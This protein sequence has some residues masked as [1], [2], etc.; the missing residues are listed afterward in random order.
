LISSVVIFGHPAWA[1][2][3][4]QAQAKSTSKPQPQANSK[5]STAATKNKL[6][7]RAVSADTTAQLQAMAAAQAAARSA[8]LLVSNTPAGANISVPVTA[9]QPDAV[10]HPQPA[11]AIDL[12]PATPPETKVLPPVAPELLIA[13]QIHQGHLPCELGASVRIEADST[14]PGF[15]HV[16]G[17]GF[18]YR[19]FPVQTTT[20][21]LRLED[22]KAGAVWLQLANKSMLMDQKRGRRL[23]DE[24]AHPDQLAYAEAMK[25][26]PPPSL[27]DTKGL[28]R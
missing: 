20:G 17:K 5:P 27:I 15:F 14:Q 28:G 13:Q 9:A 26:N 16:H 12:T 1:Q 10:V 19:M 2:S 4:S 8:A 23:A 6:S 11:H 24:C 18:R 7:P 3:Q 21:A 25:T 22:K